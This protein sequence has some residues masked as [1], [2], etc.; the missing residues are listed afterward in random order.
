M[1]AMSIQASAE[2]MDFPSPWPVGATVRARRTFARRPIGAAGADVTPC[3]S[4]AGCWNPLLRIA[5]ERDGSN[6]RRREV[7]LL[8]QRRRP[9]R[10]QGRGI[11]D[12]RHVADRRMG[13][14]RC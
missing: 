13:A 3:F 5:R 6:G 11:G 2:A 4:S 1:W 14:V 9:L 10:F 8:A 12:G 7:F